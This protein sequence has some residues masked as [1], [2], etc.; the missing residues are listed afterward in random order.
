VVTRSGNIP[1]VS[2]HKIAEPINIGDFGINLVK[3]KSRNIQGSF[4]RLKSQNTRMLT[5]I[6]KEPDGQ[7]SFY[8]QDPY[9]NILCIKEFDSWYSKNGSISVA[10]SAV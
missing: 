7:Q 6:V 1:I 5:D 3:I 8:I 2:L 4:D 9:D 10:F